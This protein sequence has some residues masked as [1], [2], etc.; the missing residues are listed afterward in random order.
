MNNIKIYLALAAALMLSACQK[1]GD[2]APGNG[3]DAYLNFYNASEVLQQNMI[4]SANNLILINDTVPGANQPQFS[5]SDDFRQ[6]PRT[7]TGNQFNIDINSIPAGTNYNIVYWMPVLAGTHHIAYTASKNVDLKD[8]TVSISPKSFTTQ[9]LVESP[10]SN[11]AYRIA[12]VPE[13]RRGIAGKVRVKVVNL[14][15]DLGPLEVIR[16]DKDGNT[17]LETLPAALKYGE[18]SAYAEIDTA[19][20]SRTRGQLILKL[21]KSGSSAILL[22]QVIDAVPNT[23][24]TVVFQGFEKETIRRIRTGSQTFQTVTVNPNLRINIR[25]IF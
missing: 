16:T 23:S 10:V 5:Q 12:T 6:F 24:F 8:T 22:T 13:E 1:S 4:L 11:E 3:Q 17:I 21:R 25:R 7:I 15:P 9:Y 20:V 2:I 18:H 19:G 14:S